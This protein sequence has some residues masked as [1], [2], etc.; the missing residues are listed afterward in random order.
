MYNLNPIQ[1]VNFH[2]S[3]QEIAGQIRQALQARKLRDECGLH[4]ADNFTS[5]RDARLSLR[6]LSLE[7]AE[8]LA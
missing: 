1:S 6:A 8:V 7:G 2:A 3:T 5:E 4:H